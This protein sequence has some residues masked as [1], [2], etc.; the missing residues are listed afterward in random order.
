MNKMSYRIIFEG[1]FDNAIRE[2]VSYIDLPQSDI[3]WA[4]IHDR[5]TMLFRMLIMA[6]EMDIITYAEEQYLKRAIKT[7]LGAI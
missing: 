3:R 1:A 5:R 7:M 6:F 4:I 2:T